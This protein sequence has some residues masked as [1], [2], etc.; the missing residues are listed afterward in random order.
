VILPAWE[1]LG[2]PAADAGARLALLRLLLALRPWLESPRETAA[3]RELLAS[4][5][6]R[7]ALRLP[8]ADGPVRLEPSAWGE[9]T[10]WIA[11]LLAL[12]DREPQG[13][14]VRSGARAAAW[15]QA[16]KAC[17]YRFPDVLE[18]LDA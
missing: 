15:V 2:L 1:A 17:G 7:A 6:A 4:P 5:E 11:R 16:A 10:A 13:A 8:P 9:L 14:S 3:L 18:L 12:L